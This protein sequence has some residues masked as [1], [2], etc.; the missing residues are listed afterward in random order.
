MQLNRDF[1]NE[2]KMWTALAL[3]VALISLISSASLPFVGLKSAEAARN[4]LIHI[5]AIG[6]IQCTSGLYTGTTYDVT[7]R[8]QTPPGGGVTIS[9][10]KFGTDVNG[11]VLIQQ[12]PKPLEADISSGQV[13]GKTFTLHGSGGDEFC[14]DGGGAIDM[15]ISGTCG[16]N[17]KIN[18]VGTAFDGTQR[19][20]GTFT[21]TVKCTKF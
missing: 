16:E 7:M 21:G 1:L 6:T 3:A 2:T 11:S 17:V 13:N 8:T 9:K 14:S 15:T 18:V 20:T 12:S 5:S 10:G 4:Y 19:L